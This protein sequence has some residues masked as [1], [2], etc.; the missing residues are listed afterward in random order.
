MARTLNNKELAAALGVDAGLLSRW[1]KRDGFP[2]DTVKGVRLADAGEV[3]AW[4]DTNIRPRKAGGGAPPETL[5]LLA[6]AEAP[7]APEKPAEKRAPTPPSPPKIPA[8]TPLAMESDPLV[9]A[10]KMRGGD[11]L[12]MSRAAVGLMARQIATQATAGTISAP[13]LDSLKK[14]LEELRRSEEAYLE[15]ATRRG[16]LLEREHAKAICGDMANRLNMCLDRIINQLA[17]Q[18]E[19]WLI[20][21]KFKTTDTEGRGRQVRTWIET[22]CTEVRR[23]EAEEID[24]LI[25]QERRRDEEGK[26]AA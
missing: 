20:D 25:E 21:D 13:Q 11:P 24:R 3:R 12:E 8:Q 1:A 16:E 2:C 26:G 14:S 17:R 9:Q 4:I 22:T 6:S 15:L 10:L 7:R 23:L 19:L 18:I 5:P